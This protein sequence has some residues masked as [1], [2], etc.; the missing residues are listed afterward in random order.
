MTLPARAA[1]G[2][3]HIKIAHVIRKFRKEYMGT[4]IAQ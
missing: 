1:R 2:Q 3:K 4:S